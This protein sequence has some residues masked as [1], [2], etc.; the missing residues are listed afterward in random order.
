MPIVEAHLGRKPIFHSIEDCDSASEHFSDKV[1]NHRET[2]GDSRPVLYSE[3]EIAWIDNEKALCQVDYMY[4][5]TRYARI[6]DA[7]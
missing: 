7:E 4:F 1:Y 3:E 2:H 5:A 6:L